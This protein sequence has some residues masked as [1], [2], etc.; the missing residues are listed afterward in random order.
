MLSAHAAASSNAPG[1]GLATLETVRQS[2]AAELDRA[3][4][5][6][7]PNPNQAVHL[8]KLLGLV[9]GLWAYRAAK[10]RLAGFP[11]DPR[12]IA[13]EAAK[14]ADMMQNDPY[15]RWLQAATLLLLGET[16]QLKAHLEPVAGAPWTG[17]WRTHFEAL[18]QWSDG[19]EGRRRAASNQLPAMAPDMRLRAMCTLPGWLDRAGT[20]LPNLLSDEASG[21]PP[22]DPNYR[23]ELSVSGHDLRDDP[24]NDDLIGKMDLPDQ[25]TIRGLRAVLARQF[26]VALPPIRL[27]RDDSLA[28]GQAKLAFDNQIV[29]SADAADLAQTHDAARWWPALTNAPV[30]IRVTLVAALRVLHRCRPNDDGQS[31]TQREA[32]ALWLSDRMP[33]GPY[34]QRLSS[35]LAEHNDPLSA[36]V[37]LRL[38]PIQDNGV[39]PLWGA[40]TWREPLLLD[41][42]SERTCS[43]GVVAGVC[44]A[45]PPDF[46]VNLVQELRRRTRAAAKRDLPAE[47]AL[48]V[49]D[50][51]LR[52]LLR[53]L[54]RDALPDLPVLALPEL[55]THARSIAVL[56]VARRSAAA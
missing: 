31:R 42:E 9:T 54:L 22:L 34:V 21:R 47:P 27:K 39:A 40:E 11:A 1:L 6:D 51:T 44:I 10:A 48:V 37:T 2:L 30:A 18:L 4:Q 46:F 43:A 14:A 7:G 35:L 20:E 38:S 13:G 32:Q 23:F 17:D 26:G 36:I 55:A 3:G 16:E 8:R 49:R 19:P 52:P 24:D 29:A 12:Q 56:E 53:V 25:P 5:P 28:A 15:L 33:Y 41:G 50:P 45:V